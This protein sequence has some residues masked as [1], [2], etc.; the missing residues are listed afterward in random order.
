MSLLDKYKDARCPHC[1]EDTISY[2]TR[3]SLVGHR[4]GHACRRC[5]GAIQLPLWHTLLYLAEI[6]LTLVVVVS[7]QLSGWAIVTVGLLAFIF[8]LFVQLPHIPIEGR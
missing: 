8:I 1:D 5:G 2:L 3:M 7:F 6:G 4:H